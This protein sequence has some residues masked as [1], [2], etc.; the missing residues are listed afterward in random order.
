M[1]CKNPWN[2][3]RLSVGGRPSEVGV[4]ADPAGK[5]GVP[6][7]S[8]ARSL[9]VGS[10]FRSSRNPRPVVIVQPQPLTSDRPRRRPVRSLHRRRRHPSR[11]T[12]RCRVSFPTYIRS[13]HPPAAPRRTQSHAS[14]TIRRSHP[15]HGRAGRPGDPVVR[16]AWCSADRI[17]PGDGKDG[18]SDRRRSGRVRGAGCAVLRTLV[19][20]ATS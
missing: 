11:A 13:R 1:T 16:R 4:S 8:G 6:P 9:C 2:P 19:R 12:P 15:G 5:A 20:I 7:P 17:R 18:W 3:T 10:S 14:R